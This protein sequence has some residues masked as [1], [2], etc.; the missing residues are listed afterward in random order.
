M[1][2]L[3]VPYIL[4]AFAHVVLLSF[5]S[6]HLECISLFL[7]D[8]LQSFTVDQCHIFPHNA[9]LVTLTG[10]TVLYLLSSDFNSL[11]L[12]PLSCFHGPK[13]TPVSLHVLISNSLDREEAFAF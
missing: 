2:F 13:V 4:M 1:C 12:A 8:L 7:L 11:N 9:Q 6:S 10:H 5:C 3:V